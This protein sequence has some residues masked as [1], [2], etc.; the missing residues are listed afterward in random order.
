MTPKERNFC[1]QVISGLQVYQQTVWL[2]T[3]NFNSHSEDHNE[4]QQCRDPLQLSSTLYYQASWK[5]G[6][7]PFPKNNVD[8]SISKTVQTKAPTQH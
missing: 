4:Q 8:F 1:N 2:S 6:P 5:Y 7:L 3:L